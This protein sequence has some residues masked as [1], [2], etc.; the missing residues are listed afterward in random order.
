[1]NFRGHVIGSEAISADP[2][3]IAA[4]ISYPAPRNQKQL[5]QFLGTYGFHHK[6]VINLADSVALLNPMLKR[7]L[8]GNEQLTYS[9][10]LKNYMHNLLITSTSCTLMMNYHV[11]FTL[12]HLNLQSVLFLCSLTKMEKH[13]LFVLHLGF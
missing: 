11:T 8:C 5:R 7:G 9:K 10:R 12:M 6:F 2:Q 3:R 1:M 4:T 13:V